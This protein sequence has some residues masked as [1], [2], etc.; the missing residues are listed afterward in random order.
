[1]NVVRSS[2]PT[3]NVVSQMVSSHINFYKACSLCKV[4]FHYALDL[5]V[6]MMGFPY[7]FEIQAHE[8]KLYVVN[9]Y[10]V[11]LYWN[12][13]NMYLHLIFLSYFII[14]KNRIKSK[15]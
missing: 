6:L 4:S 1:M 5:S 2:R 15:N 3:I 9:L 7:M 11:I 14:L 8:L 10:I 13:C 12:D